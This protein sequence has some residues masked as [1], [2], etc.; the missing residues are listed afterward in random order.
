MVTVLQFRRLRKLLQIES[1]LANAA[2]RVDLDEK[3][4][5]K[6]RDSDSLPSWR[7]V[8]RAWRPRQDPFQD[9]W[10]RTS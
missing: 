7:R 10:P 4:V 6:Y 5:R 1:T 3:T 2:D 8:S 9:L